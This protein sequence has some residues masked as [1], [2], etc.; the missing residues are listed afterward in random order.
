[1]AEQQRAPTTVRLRQPAANA[2]RE[3]WLE[4]KHTNV[5]LSYPEFASEVVLDG[6]K[7]RKRRRK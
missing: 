1:V 2:L 7:A 6:L 3:A 5:L 4:E